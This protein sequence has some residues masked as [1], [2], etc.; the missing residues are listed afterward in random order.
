MEEKYSK[1]L[2]INTLIVNLLFFSVSIVSASVKTNFEEG[3][4]YFETADYEKAIQKFESARKQGLRSTSLYYNIA[5]TYFKLEKYNKSKRYFLELR[6]LPKMKSLAEYNLG[7]ISSK[8]G[9]NKQARRYFRSV[10]RSNQDA[11][12]VLLSKNQISPQSPKHNPLSIYAGLSLGYDDNIN[13]APVGIVA[14]ESDFY[15]DYILS[16]GYQIQGNHRNG[17]VVDAVLADTNYMDTNKYDQ[18]QYGAGLKKAKRYNRWDTHVKLAF[19]NIDYSHDDY[20][21]I[22]K[23]QGQGKYHWSRSNKVYLSYRYDDISNDIA[24]YSYLDGWR[25][26]F[27]AEFRN[28]SKSAKFRMYYELELNDRKDLVTLSLQEISYSPTRHGLRVKYSNDINDNW[29]VTGDIGYRSSDYPAT[30]TQNR[31]DDR[32]RFSVYAD[33][34]I[35]KDMTVRYRIEYT[36]NSSTD[37]LYD[38]T[39]TVYTLSLNAFF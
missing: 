3:V 10:I 13:V 23:L 4:A 26:K 22:I 31:S 20:L 27:K 17:W 9:D 7:L 2:V 32:K 15:L 33:N 28:Y 11:K 37:L 39:R 30:S 36:D 35:N 34:K 21:T 29:N 8:L 1:W 19:D 25:Q 18:K 24:L 14:N 16:A 38:Y 6:K 5:A 12:L